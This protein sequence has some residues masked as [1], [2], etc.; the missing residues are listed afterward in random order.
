M[1]RGQY[2]PNGAYPQEL[3]DYWRFEDGTIRTD[4]PELSDEELTE[5][6]WHGPIQMPPTPGTSYFTHN[7]EWNSETL[8]FDATEVDEQEKERRVDYQRLWN[9]LINTSAYLKIKKIE[10]RLLISNTFEIEFINFMNNASNNHV[11]VDKI[12]KHSSE[13][14]ANIN[15]TEEELVEIQNVFA[16]SGMSDIF[17]LN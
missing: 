7:Y 5:L 15:F 8:S 4:L 14:F 9:E 2:S 16:N 12:Q 6:G 1:E 17:T 11:N 13:I 10:S 3:P